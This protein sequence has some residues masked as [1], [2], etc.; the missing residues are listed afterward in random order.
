[1]AP[2]VKALI[3]VDEARSTSMTTVV[4][5]VKKSSSAWTGENRTS[6]LHFSFYFLTNGSFVTTAGNSLSLIL[7]ATLLPGAFCG[8]ST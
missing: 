1:M 7:K 3:I 8:L 6:S 4:F 5:P 2:F